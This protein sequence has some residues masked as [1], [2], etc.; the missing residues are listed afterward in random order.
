[1]FEIGKYNEDEFWTY[2]IMGRA[3]KIVKIDDILY[4]YYQNTASIMGQGYKFKRL[5][6]I[7]AKVCRKKYIDKNYPEL[8][9]IAATNLMGSIIYAGQMSIAYLDEE[10]RNK[11]INI[12]KGYIKDIFGNNKYHFLDTAKQKL[13]LY[14]GKKLLVF[15]CKLRNTLRMNI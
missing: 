15:T 9:D 12:L 11:A 8:S 5:D 14:M 1:M 13:W 7:E 6:A 10:E 2:Q 3:R 4:Y